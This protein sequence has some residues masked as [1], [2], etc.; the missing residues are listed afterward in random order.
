ML[1]SI[2]RSIVVRCWQ[3]TIIVTMLL[4]HELTI[5]DGK[6]LLIV[7]NNDWTMVVE[8]EQ[9]WTMV[10]DN[11]CWQRLLTTVVDN[12]CW[13]GAAQHCNK[14]LTTLIKLFIFARVYWGLTARRLIYRGLTAKILIYRGLTARDLYIGGRLPDDLYIGVRFPEDLYIGVY[15]Y[16]RVDSENNYIHRELTA[17]AKFEALYII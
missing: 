3:R 14:L 2:V 13:Q 5:V 16:I 6:S 7:F 4:E 17:K 15:L 11:G 12:G 10:V 1:M 9:L 8:R